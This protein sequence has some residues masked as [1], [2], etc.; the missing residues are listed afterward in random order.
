MSHGAGD[1][2]KRGRLE[3]HIPVRI[4]CRETDGAEWAELSHILDVTQ[5]GASFTLSR[6]MAI[7]RIIHMSLPLPWRLRQYD[8]S[9]ELYRIYALVRWVK[10]LDEGFSIGVAFVG[11][12]PP[13]SWLRDPSKI[14]SP[15][16]HEGEKRREGRIQAALA[17]QL[18][19]IDENGDV[20]SSEVT[21]TENI[22][23]H[24]ASCYTMLEP[25]PGTVLRVTSQQSAFSTTGVVRRFRT[26]KDNIPRIHI[27]F[28]GEDWP[29][30]IDEDA[31]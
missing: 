1:L 28:V 17:V 21:V 8:H 25:K 4:R 16:R 10:T 7:G 30:D 3:L 22:S 26:G 6:P 29:L 18:D 12:N 9:E 24:G 27:E 20:L 19:L 5:L 13:A 2:R 31:G 14:Y 23:R 11:K 15:G